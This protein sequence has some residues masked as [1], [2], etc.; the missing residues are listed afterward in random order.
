MILV[1]AAIAVWLAVS[2]T[3]GLIFARAFTLNEER[4]SSERVAPGSPQQRL[5]SPDL[6]R[7]A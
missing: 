5:P 7:A 6:E 4:K 3:A 2:V 1:F